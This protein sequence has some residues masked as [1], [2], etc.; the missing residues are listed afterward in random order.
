[1]KRINRMISLFMVAVLVLSSMEPCAVLAEGETEEIPVQG[2]KHDETDGFNGEFISVESLDDEYY[3]TCIPE[4]MV[5]ANEDIGVDDTEDVMWSGTRQRMREIAEAELGETDSSIY[6]ARSGEDWCAYFAKWVAREA[7]LGSDIWPETASTTITQDKFKRWGRWYD[8]VDYTWSYDKPGYGLTSGGGGVSEV[9]PQPGDF[10]AIE[11]KGTAS[12]GPEHTGM[13]YDVSADGNTIYT[14]EGNTSKPGG[15]IGVA[16]K[17][18]TRDSNNRWSRA[19]GV[20]IVGFGDLGIGGEAPKPQSSFNY[21]FEEV[22]GGGGEV[23][24]AGWIYDKSYPSRT[25]ELHVYVG[26]DGGDY[27]ID[28]TGGIMANIERPDVNDVFGCGNYHGFDGKARTAGRGYQTIYVYAIGYDGMY[29]PC[30]YQGTVYISD[31]TYTITFDKSSYEVKEGS[32]LDIGFKYARNDSPSGI[33]LSCGFPEDTYLTNGSLIENNAVNG[34]GH[35]TIRYNTVKAGS[36]TFTAIMYDENDNEIYRKSVSVKVVSSSVHPTGVTLDKTKMSIENGKTGTLTATVSPS[37]STNKSVT[38]SSNN[39]SVAVVSNTGVVTAKSVGTATI[40]AKTVDGGKTAVCTVTVEPA[41]VAV[42]GVKLN[43]NELSL[44]VGKSEKLY[45]TVSPS[46]ASEKTIEWSSQYTNIATVDSNGKV[47]AVSTGTTWIYAKAKSSNIGYADKC[48]VTVT[49]TNIP[50]SGIT[51]SKADTT[52][53][54]GKTE[55][56]KATILPSNSTNKSVGWSSDNTSVATVST[57][58][59]V[60]TKAPGVA[61]ITVKTKEGGFTASCKVTVVQ[62]V[63]GVELNKSSSRLAVGNSEELTATITPANATNKAV[64]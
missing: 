29:N 58:G 22:K 38:W 25:V 64:Y 20:W 52:I 3:G 9:K 21:N 60:T 61:I 47:T 30:V 18:Y 16:Q 1:M 24:I 11:T 44:D 15:G 40:T 50:P 5:Y 59:T 17:T 32:N 23:S 46:N 19:S 28:A 57:V 39:S 34:G 31:P 27:W 7:G 43:K 37:D 41:V 4:G 8:K 14:I 63:T 45:A 56:L 2:D 62:P 12:N 35:C 55:T 6:G 53:D 33:H 13:V 42:T 54:V 10:V 51:L 26:G 36:T 49:M 48:K